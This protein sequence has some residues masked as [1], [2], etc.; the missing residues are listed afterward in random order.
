[1]NKLR[2]VGLTS[3]GKTFESFKSD[4]KIHFLSL[5]TNPIKED[6]VENFLIVN[7][8]FDETCDLFIVKTNNLAATFLMGI[9]IS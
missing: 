8:I 3:E 2:F 4:L 9:S 7:A 6:N 5:M 1:M